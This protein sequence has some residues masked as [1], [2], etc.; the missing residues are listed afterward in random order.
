[1]TLCNF[2]RYCIM[3]QDPTQHDSEIV[4]RS[5]DRQQ[6]TEHACRHV[7]GRIGARV[8]FSVA[9]AEAY[10]ARYNLA[11]LLSSMHRRQTRRVAVA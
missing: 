8:M 3:P 7:T 9:S 2:R 11:L 4:L 10:G 5:Q 6:C 1:M